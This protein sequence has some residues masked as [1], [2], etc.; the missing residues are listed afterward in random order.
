MGTDRRNFISALGSAGQPGEPQ[1]KPSAP[2]IDQLQWVEGQIVWWDAQIKAAQLRLSGVVRVAPADRGYLA[3]HADVIY[4]AP[5]IENEG[6]R[7]T[8]EQMQR[9]Q[10]AWSKLR[11]YVG[12]S[13]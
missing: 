12:V 11:T 1:P 6:K 8:K 2:A 5:G 7:L 13:P 3:K 10:A 9:L 4:F